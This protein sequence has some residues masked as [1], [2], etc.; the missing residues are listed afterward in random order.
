[1]QV[2]LTYAEIYLLYDLLQ[3]KTHGDRKMQ[4]AEKRLLEKLESLIGPEGE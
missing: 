3:E 2:E 4:E 1:M